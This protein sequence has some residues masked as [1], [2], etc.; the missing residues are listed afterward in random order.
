VQYLLPYATLVLFSSNSDILV[1]LQVCRGLPLLRFPCGFNSRA[2]LATCPSVLLS[3]WPIQLHAPCFNLLHSFHHLPAGVPSHFTHPQ[4]VDTLPLHLLSHLG[5]LA[6][7]ERCP[8]VPLPDLHTRFWRQQ[9]HQR[10]KRHSLP[11]TLI[12]LGINILYLC[13]LTVGRSGNT[14]F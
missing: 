14:S 13:F 6:H 7:L 4:N 5:T 8:H 1:R 12:Q 11:R 3:V 9:F 2:L 10:F